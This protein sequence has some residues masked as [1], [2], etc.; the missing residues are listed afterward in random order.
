MILSIEASIAYRHSYSYLLIRSDI[1]IWS[2]WS[3]EIMSAGKSLKFMVSMMNAYVSIVP[4][5]FGGTAPIFLIICHWLP[6]SM[7]RYFVCMEGLVQQSMIPLMKSDLSIENKKYHMMEQCVIWCGLILMVHTT[8]FRNC[9][10]DFK[11]SWG[12]V[13]IRWEHCGEVQS[14]K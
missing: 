7:I 12:W 3:E 4:W 2:H 11:S 13:L 8:L 1:P 10:M 9:W 5:M 14:S 6:L